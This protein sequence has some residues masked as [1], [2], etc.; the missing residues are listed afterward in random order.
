LFRPQLYNVK[1]QYKI[2]TVVHNFGKTAKL[3]LDYDFDP[4][5]NAS[6]RL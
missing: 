3:Q 5:A 4:G 6:K 2:K 1:T